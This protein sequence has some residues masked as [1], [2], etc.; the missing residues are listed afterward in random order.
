MLKFALIA[1]AVMSLVLPI[2]TGC[3]PNAQQSSDNAQAPTGQVSP[4]SPSPATGA[5]M[6]SPSDQ[7]FVTKAVQGGLAE[8]QLG[9]LANQNASNVAVR[10]FGQRMVTDHTQANNRLQ[11]VAAQKDVTLPT[12][13]GEENQAVFDRLSNLTGPE[14]DRQYMQH[15]VEDHTQDVSLYQQQSQQGEDT[16][17]KAFATQTLPTLQEHLQ[18]AQSIS[19]SLPASGTP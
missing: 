4:A 9:Q 11:Q 13:L 1:S 17:L 19:E 3:N 5:T 2:A 6:L 18:L 7:E 12:D 10:D 14:F 16:D 15:M 8:V